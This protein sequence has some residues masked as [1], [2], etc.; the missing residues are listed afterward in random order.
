ML[1]EE[2]GLAV[3]QLRGLSFQ[4]FGDLGVQLLSSVAQQAAVSRVLHQRVLETID[5]IGR[6]AALEH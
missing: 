5:R 3:H 4:R 2:L 1:R 6:H